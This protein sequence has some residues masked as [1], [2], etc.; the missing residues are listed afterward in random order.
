M[1]SLTSLRT[2]LLAALM[3]AVVFQSC[4][5]QDQPD[6]AD[7]E[8]VKTY[9]D[10]NARFDLGVEAV[11]MDAI[12]AVEA[13]PILS[14]ERVDQFSPCNATVTYDTIGTNRQVTIVYNGNNCANTHQLSGTVTVTMPLGVQWVQPNATMTIDIDSLHIIR[15][16]DNNTITLNGTKVITNVTGGL[17]VNLPTAGTIVHTILGN[18]MSINFSDNTQR[19]WSIARQREFTYNNGVVIANTGLHTEDGITGIAE[20]GIGRNGA[21]FKS[22][23][24]EAVT[25]RQDCDYRITSGKVMHKRSL[26]TVNV[27]FGLDAQGIPTTCPG[28]NNPYYRKVEWVNAQGQSQ[29]ILQPY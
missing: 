7:L 29:S 20:W 3:P 2:F 17:L 14:G 12:S 4:K 16:S 10:D 21:P 26:I 22:V 8:N 24:L 11:S 6:T 9:T 25:R 19:T 23:V 15:L 27:T 13:A 1:L 18:N 28:L 5:K